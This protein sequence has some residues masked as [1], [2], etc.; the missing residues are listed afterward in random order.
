MI[1]RLALRNF[2]DR[3]WR[4]AFLLGG[5][6]MGVGVMIV[7]LSI[8]EALLAQARDERLVGGG[9]ITVLPEGIDVEVMKTGGLGGMFFSIPNARFIHLQLL[10]SPRLADSVAAVAPRI[11]GTLLY[12]RTLG[13]A[14]IPVRATGEIPSR[15][16]AVG[17]GPEL[18]AGEWDDDDQDRRW[19]APT[20]AE[21]YADIDR[22]HLPP[23]GLAVPESWAEWH[24]F[25]VLSPGGR[26][27][28]FISF[29]LG[30]NI[31]DGEWGGR[32][33]VTLH[34]I[35][36]RERR[37]IA[38]ARP[39]A[40]RFSTFHPDLDIGGSTVRLLDDGRY[41]VRGRAREEGGEMALDVDLVFTPS[42]RAYFPSASLGD[43][44]QGFVSGYV[45][46]ALRAAA[47]GRICA[48]GSCET[49]D[50]ALGYH[51]HNWGIWAGVTW[52]WGIARAGQYSILYGQVQPPDTIAATAPLFVY[53]V[54]SLGFLGIFRPARVHYEDARTIRV[55]GRPVRVPARA[56]IADARGADTL[57]LEIEIEDA[58]GTDIRRPVV[59]GGGEAVLFE[60][61]RPYFIQMKGRARLSG[62]IG[63]EVIGAEGQGFFETYR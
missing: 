11:E 47:T 63:G 4:T 48:G 37:F 46:P 29:V 30:G 58:S 26:R 13:G 52:E 3:P 12:L 1:A 9:D 16:R 31:P 19:I 6:G 56:L 36:Q 7:L 62:R 54:D 23:P 53:V 2:L 20:A 55:D 38:D 17:A 21:L 22:F 28:A 35:G 24:Y 45:V 5:Y 40:V 59:V 14:E 49:Y 44:S 41:H 51:D 39:G 33:L 25:N 27:W 60:P 34:G 10:A 18:S 61:S 8:G 43:E 42:P 32:V 15:T 57:R 50:G